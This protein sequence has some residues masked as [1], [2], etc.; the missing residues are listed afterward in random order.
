MLAIEEQIRALGS[1]W[2]M[3][4]LSPI[5]TLRGIWL[6]AQ[7]ATDESHDD[8]APK[9]FAENTAISGLST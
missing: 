2:A 3:G 7:K 9:I 4:A 8:H 1:P 5:Y 6:T